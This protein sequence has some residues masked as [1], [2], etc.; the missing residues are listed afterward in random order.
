MLQG[1]SGL[2]L[3]EEL[4]SAMPALRVIIFSGLANSEE[5]A[6]EVKRRG[7]AAF[8]TKGCDFQVLLDALRPSQAPRL[9]G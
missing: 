8:V 2:P 5:V 9:A 4:T 6:R 1:G 7:A 3:V